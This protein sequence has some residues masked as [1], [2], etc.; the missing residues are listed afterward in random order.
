[1]SYFAC[2]FCNQFAFECKYANLQKNALT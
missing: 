2:L 1:L